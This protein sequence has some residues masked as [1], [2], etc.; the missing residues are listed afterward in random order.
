MTSVL[1]FKTVG[2]LALVLGLFLA[3]IYALKRWGKLSGRPASQT[4]E[5]LSRQSFGPRHHLI[6]VKVSGE[7]NVLVGIS[8]RNMSLLCLED[9]AAQGGKPSRDMDENI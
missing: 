8:P 5:V 3:F 9:P 6:L 7:R 2:A 4:M 1:L